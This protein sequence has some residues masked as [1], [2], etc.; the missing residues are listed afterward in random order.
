MLAMK[1]AIILVVVLLVFGGLAYYFL[2][3]LQEASV[4]EFR[5]KGV[6][7][8]NSEAF[9]LAGDLVVS[10]PSRVA[11]P[12]D[13]IDY[14]VVL[15]AANKELARGVLPGG[16]IAPGDTTLPVA[17]DVRWDSV[18]DLFLTIATYEKANVEVRG[19]I[20]FA[21]QS[22][23][24]SDLVDIKQVLAQKAGGSLPL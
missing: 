13:K 5:L 7:G 20:Y 14:T 15:L 21:G 23:A 1:A 19:R 3:G 18:L 4:K 22:V 6:A 11:I 2:G 16:S 10:N 17:I 12:Y 9:A 24:F 8:L